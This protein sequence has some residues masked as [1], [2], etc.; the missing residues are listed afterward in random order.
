MKTTCLLNEEKSADFQ[1]KIRRKNRIRNDPH[2][3]VGNSRRKIKEEQK[4][5]KKKRIENKKIKIYRDSSVVPSTAAPAI[6]TRRIC[7]KIGP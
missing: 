6:D 3:Y 2:I 4:Q 7:T 5:K 1:P